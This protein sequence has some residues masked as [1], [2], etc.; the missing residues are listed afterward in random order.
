MDIPREIPMRTVNDLWTM[1][2]NSSQK[3]KEQGDVPARCVRTYLLHKFHLVRR[4]P[5]LDHLNW[6]TEQ[7]TCDSF[8]T[9]HWKDWFVETLL[10]IYFRNKKQFDSTVFPLPKSS[11]YCWGTFLASRVWKLHQN[12]NKFQ[13]EKFFSREKKELCHTFKSYLIGNKLKFS[14]CGRKSEDYLR[15]KSYKSKCSVEFPS[16]KESCVQNSQGTR[17]ILETR[18]TSE[19]VDSNQH[20]PLK[21]MKPSGAGAS[22]D[23]VGV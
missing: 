15:P 16:E 9:F 3:T 4:K 12:G 21:G 7:G 5:F 10:T 14:M 22:P 20:W 8:W 11:V 6:N 1:W 19:T 18:P 23:L 13:F 17:C 2:Q